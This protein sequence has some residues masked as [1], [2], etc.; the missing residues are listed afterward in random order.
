MNKDC[1]SIVLMFLKY[2]ELLNVATVN[3]M[4]L[5]L[6]QNDDLWKRLCENDD[7][8]YPVIKTTKFYHFDT[9]KTYFILEKF[10]NKY[11]MNLKNTFYS[12]TLNLSHNKLSV[13]PT[14]IGALTNL[15]RLWLNNN[16]LSVL[17]TEIGALTNLRNLRMNNNK[18]S[19]LPAEIGSLTNLQY[20]SL[21]NNKLSVLPAEIGALTNL[22]T[23]WLHS[24]KLSVLPAEIG[25][26][27]N[28]H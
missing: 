4:F 18:L 24:N 23:L 11:K 27:T 16:N 15:Q 1:Y 13:I 28:L 7:F 3:K 21:N 19:V 2:D 9:Y 6:S 22:Q 12:K 5:E 14:E 20:L 8:I 10:L 26:L 25:A 17:P